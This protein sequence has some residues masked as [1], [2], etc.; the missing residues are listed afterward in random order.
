MLVEHVL[1]SNGASG[2]LTFAHKTQALRS[3]PSNL[4]VPFASHADLWD[5]LAGVYRAFQ[6][7]RHALTHR[8]AGTATAG[9]LRVYDD[10]GHQTDVITCLEITSFA[11]VALGSSDLV[12]TSSED[13]RQL[14]ELAWHL[15]QL[16][17]R[18][19]LSL[20]AGASLGDD[21]RLIKATLH[22]LDQGHWQL[23]VG[24]VREVI[25]RQ[26]PSAV[27]DLELYADPDR[28]FVA[29]WEGIPDHERVESVEF[30]GSLLPDWLA[31]EIPRS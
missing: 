23:D 3:R 1:R 22:P 8:R 4:P 24:H 25:A 29:R 30:D 11:A 13:S 26:P 6:D 16:R 27:W 9:G 17:A 15:N 21:L 18:H 2:R 28:M 10:G 7:A 12:V 20:I 19:G 5:R 31:E 14:R